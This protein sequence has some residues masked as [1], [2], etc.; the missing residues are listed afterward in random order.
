[1]RQKLFY[2][3]VCGLLLNAACATMLNA[4]SLDQ[5]VKQGIAL[6]DSGKVHEAVN[7]FNEALKAK[8]KHSTANYELGK[9]YLK[10]G[11][12][13]NAEKYLNL[14][15]TYGYDQLK[16]RTALIS[17]YLMGAKT[18]EAIMEI[19]T[20]LD[21]KPK[22]PE[23][24]ALL[25]DAYLQKTGTLALAEEEYRTALGLDSNYV[26]AIVG[27]GN[28]FKAKRQPT[29]AF[30]MFEKAL[31]LNPKYAPAYYSY[32]LVLAEKKMYDKSILQLNEYIKLEPNDPKGY[33]KLADIYSKVAETVPQ[34]KI[35]YYETAIANVNLAIAYGDTSLGTLKFLSFLMRKAVHPS[36]NKEVLKKILVKTPDD[37]TTWIELG[38]TYAKL[39]SYALAIPVYHKALAIDTMQ[40]MNLAFTMGFAYYQVSKFDSAVVMF[41]EKIKRDTLAAGAYFNRALAYLQLKKSESK[42]VSDLEKGIKIQPNYI[43]GHLW[44]AQTYH[45]LGN[46][47]KARIE[48]KAVLK[49]DPKNQDAQ[50]G[51]KMLDQVVTSTGGEKIDYTDDYDPGD[52]LY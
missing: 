10:L 9:T 37:V 4:V 46:K 30:V 20:V 52:T 27:M 16:A 8:P 11:D 38:Q 15:L 25:G 45:F 39:D 49:L 32:A 29:D 24:H 26:P 44:L 18:Q 14:A 2:I 5:L 1:M 42:A 13:A 47:A 7:R 33:T 17:A 6:R 21:L 34:E 19:Q 23:L 22:S 28:Y 35:K 12:A 40:W 3:A 41:T 51:I 36:D 50:K 31:K 43:Q 48:Y